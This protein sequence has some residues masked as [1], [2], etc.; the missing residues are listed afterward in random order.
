MKIKCPDCGARYRIDPGRTNKTVPRIKCPQCTTVFQVTLPE[1]AEWAPSSPAEP[2]P[3]LPRPG[4]AGTKVLVVDDSKFFR[5]LVVDVLKSL[6]F[7]FLTAG[8]GVEALQLIR[9]ELPALV[10]LDLNLPSGT[11]GYRLIREVRADKALQNIRLLAMSGVFRQPED[12]AEV[13]K[14]GADD[15]INKSFKPEQLQA[16]VTALL[17]G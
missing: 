6:P 5:E 9:R 3:R 2:A 11:D 17:E 7:A 15:F 13:E 1:R 16:R 12:A 8:D 14:A 10:I 4:E